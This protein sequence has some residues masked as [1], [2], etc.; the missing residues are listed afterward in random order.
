VRVAI[1]KL[2][3]VEFVDVSLERASAVIR[4]R[5]ENRVTLPPLRQI[6]KNNGFSAREA[7]IAAVGTLVE[8]GGRPAVSVTGTE[9]VWLIAS[10]GSRTGAYE[11][12]VRRI[13]SGQA[14]P[15][16]ITG[17]VPVPIDPNQPEEVT[18]DVLRPAP[19]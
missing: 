4:L 13:K 17:T 12:A 10:K 16:E 14:G 6:I 1:R 9:I 15:V 19:K 8:R 3:G 5:P 7:T 2:D 11:D 18:I